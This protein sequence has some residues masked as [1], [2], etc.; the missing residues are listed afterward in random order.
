MT[1][2]PKPLR[3]IDVIQTS[4]R[5]AAIS[6]LLDRKPCC[7]VGYFWDLRH[8]LLCDLHYAVLVPWLFFMVYSE[9]Y[10]GFQKGFSPRVAARANYLRDHATWIRAIFAPVFCMG[11]FDSTKKRKI[12]LWALLIMVTSFVILFQYIPQPWRGILDLGVV[13]G[14][15]WGLMATLIYFAKFWFVKGSSTDPEIPDR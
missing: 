2:C 15:S 6:Q 10:K 7:P 1:D 3:A 12:V 4:T 13:V 9:G 14:L 8:A 5:N 11:F